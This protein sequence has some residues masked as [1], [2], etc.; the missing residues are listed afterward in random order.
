MFY[1]SKKLLSVLDGSCPLKE[2]VTVQGAGTYATGCTVGFRVCGQNRIFGRRRCQIGPLLG[3]PGGFRCQNRVPLIFL[4]IMD[5]STTK[6]KLSGPISDHFWTKNVLYFCY[7]YVICY[8]M[9][10]FLCCFLFL[11]EFSACCVVVRSEKN[12]LTANVKLHRRDQQGYKGCGSRWRRDG[13]ART[14]RVAVKGG[15]AKGGIGF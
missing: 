1:K 3:L 14:G 5:C 13:V 8:A 4:C 2:G 15:R 7:V 11:H 10:M 12:R 9:L 6:N